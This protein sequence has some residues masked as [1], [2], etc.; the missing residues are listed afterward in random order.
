[1][2]TK[3]EPSSKVNWIHRQQ[4]QHK[5]ETAT[6]AMQKRK[7]VQ[8]INFTKVFHATFDKAL[9]TFRSVFSK[10]RDVRVNNTHLNLIKLNSKYNLRTTAYE[11]EKI[12]RCCL[13]TDKV[14]PFKKAELNC[15]PKS[16]QNQPEVNETIGNLCCKQ[17]RGLSHQIYVEPKNSASGIKFYEERQH[18][19]ENPQTEMSASDAVPNY[20]SN[21]AMDVIEIRKDEGKKSVTF[22]DFKGLMAPVF[23]CFNDDEKKT[24]NISYIDRYAKWLKSKNIDGVLVNSITGEGPSLG[25][26]ERKLNAEWWWRAA[27]ENSLM[28]MLQ[29]GGGALPD[30]LEM[31]CYAEELGVHSVCCLPEIFY[32]PRNIDQLIAYC[33]LVAK[34]CP[35]RPF[36]YHH[37]PRITNVNCK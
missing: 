17:K 37:I 19:R 26:L 20:H 14:S 6:T 35:S 13:S 5:P 21:D 34:T 15:K 22:F 1:M 29:I 33:K 16:S 30:V 36:F 9:T 8:E 25:L 23:T 32:K 31:G 2:N 3:L 4:G 24:V 10:V 11:E 12:N 27:S 18:K 7:H 28:M